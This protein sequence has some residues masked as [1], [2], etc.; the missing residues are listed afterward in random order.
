MD[1]MDTVRDSD[2]LIHR[3]QVERRLHMR[4]LERDL[5]AIKAIF[6]LQGSQRSTLR[7]SL[8]AESQYRCNGRIIS[9]P[10]THS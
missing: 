9:D 10:R 7:G 6:D 8:M 3:T 5:Q 2:A 4:R 1:E